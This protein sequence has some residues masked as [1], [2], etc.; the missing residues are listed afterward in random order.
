MKQPNGDTLN[1]YGTKKVY[2]EN[3]NRTRLLENDF[4]VVDTI[5]PLVSVKD[6]NK[7]GQ[8]V[9]FGPNRRKIINDPEVIA[10]IE[11]YLEQSEGFDIVQDTAGNFRLVGDLWQP[12]QDPSAAAGG[13]LG[14]S[15]DAKNH[16]GAANVFPVVSEEMFKKALS[17]ADKEIAKEETNRKHIAEALEHET[18]QTVPTKV[19]RQPRE[20]TQEEHDQHAAQGCTP[21]RDWCWHC[22]SGQ[23]PDMRH[24]RTSGGTPTTQA[25]P[26]LLYTSPS[27]RDGLLSRMPSSA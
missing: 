25:N 7:K 26:C 5:V 13:N 22:V 11:M 21:Y 27:P 12:D 6:R 1:H 3:W 2:Y 4:E 20:P 9:C 18:S 23:C 16:G 17:K 8:L 15:L 14:D 19:P 10:W 24:E